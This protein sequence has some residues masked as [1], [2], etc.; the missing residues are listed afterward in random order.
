M[1]TAFVRRLPIVLAVGA[2]LMVLA[3]IV[4]RTRG[5]TP[6]ETRTSKVD[7]KINAPFKKPNVRDYINKFE[8]ESRENYARRHEIVDALGLEP[9]MAVA[10]VGAGTGL[11]TRLFAEKVGPK[12]KVY[13]VDIAE[14]FL[15][16]IDAEAKKSGHTHVVTVLGSQDSTNLPAESVDL[17][18]LSDVYHHLEK[19]EKTLAS[20]HRALRPGGR[21]VV[22]E[23]DR[24][25]GKSS[26]F[27]LKHVRA[28]QAVFRKEIESAGFAVIPTP[29][30]PKLKE[31]FF[32][33]FEKR[34]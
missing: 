22:I 2:S 11:F 27:V 5:Q 9:G 23:F 17:V 8:T 20:I 25:E 30:P 16:H 10:D 12:G 24:V 7:P 4:G 29:R 18:F 15:K 26:A 1:H 33:R 28:S 14:P 21:L 34:S 3:A 6:A 32:L 31:N 13:A 19:P